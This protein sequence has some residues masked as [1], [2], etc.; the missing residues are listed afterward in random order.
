[1][2]ISTCIRCKHILLV[3]C[4]TDG[5]SPAI[6]SELRCGK[7]GNMIDAHLTVLGCPIL[8]FK[9]SKMSEFPVEK[10]VVETAPTEVVSA[11]GEVCAEC[12][13]GAFGGWSIPNYVAKC[14]ECP[15]CLRKGRIDG[16]IDLR[17][18]KCPLGHHD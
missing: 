14:R 18:R 17:H 16:V 9:A 11:R 15:E 3:P 5:V 4:P 6:A 8:K 7:T 13:V 2:S 10:R 1:V 12:P